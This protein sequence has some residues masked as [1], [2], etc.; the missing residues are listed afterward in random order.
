MG[1]GPE[2]IGWGQSAWQYHSQ[3]PRVIACGDIVLSEIFA[4]YGMYETQHQ[5]AVAVGNIHPQLEKA[6]QVARECY[7]IGVSYLKEGVTFGEVADEMEKPLLASGGWHV[8]PQ[9]HSINPY[10]PIGF[11]TAPGTGSEGRDELCI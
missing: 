11:G 9:I 6:A 3:K 2:Y 5:A 10:G 8:H 4:L 7:D 1:S